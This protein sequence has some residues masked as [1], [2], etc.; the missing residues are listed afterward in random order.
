MAAN[1]A[2]SRSTDKR[3]YGVV[4]AL[5]VENEDPE[6][7]GRVKLK[8]P[9]FDEQ[10]ITDWCRV[11][12]FY[13]GNGYGSFYVPEVDDEVLV[14]F[15]HGDM[16]YPVVVGGLYN[17]SDKPAT[18]RAA[19]KDEKLIRTKA[20]HQIIL[21]DSNGEQK[22]VIVDKS[23]NNRIEISTADDSITIEAKT[24]KLKLKGNGIEI[25]SAAGITMEATGTADIKG[26][27]I[28]LN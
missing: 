6:Q 17:G 28:N 5:V 22:I 11:S 1:A 12:Q 21:D 8:F 26:A 16:R 27:T 15:V 9:W 2:R 14:A 13:A 3:F 24:G 19:D 7:E 25:T 10:M 18:H 4:E 20:G 23:E